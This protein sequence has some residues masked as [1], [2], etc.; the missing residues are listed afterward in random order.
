MFD[1]NAKVKKLMMKIQSSE[2]LLRLKKFLMI[3]KRQENKV[4]SPL[5]MRKGECSKVSI[6]SCVWKIIWKMR[7]LGVGEDVYGGP[8]IIYCPLKKVCLENG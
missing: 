6:F 1:R 7:V 2:K 8:V 5:K 3:M 4:L